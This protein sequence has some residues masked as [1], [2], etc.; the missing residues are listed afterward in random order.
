MYPHLPSWDVVWNLNPNIVRK[1][2]LTFINFRYQLLS[3]P[4]LSHNVKFIPET[5]LDGLWLRHTR[6]LRLSLP[7]LVHCTYFSDAPEVWA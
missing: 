3:V 1:L 2:A 5:T 6:H 7:V 4:E